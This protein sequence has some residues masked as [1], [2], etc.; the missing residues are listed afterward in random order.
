MLRRWGLYLVLVSLIW[1]GAQPSGVAAQAAPFYAAEAQALL[2]QMSVAER[3]GQLFLIPFYGDTAGADSEIADLIVNHHIGGVVMLTENDNVTD[4]SNAPLQVARLNQQLQELALRP[5][6]EDLTSDPDLSQGL[7]QPRTPIP[8]FIALQ[9]E[10]DG[11]PHSDLWHGLTPIPNQMALGATW[12]PE[13]ARLVGEIVGR[14]LSILGVNLLLGPSLD[15]L[16]NPDPNS[17]SDLGTRTFGGDPYW[18]GLMG[19]AYTQGVQQGSQGSMAVIAK[20][21][22]GYGGSDRPLNEEIATVRKSLAELEQ[23]DLAP[24][25]MVTASDPALTATVRVDG[26]LT[27]HIRYQGLSGNIR[28]TTAPVSFSPTA[29]AELMALPELAEWRAQGG[30]VVSDALGVQA[31]QRFYDDT[32][33]EFPHRQVAKDAFL[34][35]NDLLYL[36]EFALAATRTPESENANIRDTIAWFQERYQ[37]EPAFRQRVDASVLR[38]LQLKLRLYGGELD[39]GFEAPMPEVWSALQEQNASVLV[40][41]PS[42]ALTL[43][44]PRLDEPSAGLPAPPMADENIVIFTQLRLAQACS[45]CPP[46]PYLAPTALQERILALYGPFASGQVAPN[47]IRSFT[48]ADLNDYLDAG[49]APIVWNPPTPTPTPDPLTT[50]DAAAPTPTAAPPA[51]PPP[52]FLVQ[53]ALREADWLLFALLD[54]QTDVEAAS[55]NAL[56]R[57]LSERPDLARNRR[58]VVMAYNIPYSL[59]ATDISKLTAYFG[60]YSKIPAFVDASIQAL[61]NDI[62]LNGNPPVSLNG[63]GYD[64]FRVTQPDPQQQLGLFIYRDGERLMPS[65]NQPV[66][67]EPDETVEL[68]TG[69]IVDHNGNPVPDGAVVRFIQED[70]TENL[71]NVVTERTTQGGVASLE[72]LLPDRLVGRIRVRLSAGEANRSDEIYILGNEALVI[73]PT[74]QPTRTPTATPTLTPSPT[75]TPSPVPSPTLTPTPPAPAPERVVAIPLARVQTLL[76]FLGGVLATVVLALLVMSRRPVA[77]TRQVRQLLWA[78]VAGLLAYNY[79]ALGLPGMSWL[80]QPNAGLGLAVTFV[81]GAAGFFLARRSA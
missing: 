76:G 6:A 41:L 42:Q 49:G 58:V 12:E 50:P 38:L 31:V 75:A 73:T 23:F 45:A 33:Q 39:R 37:V 22:P 35:G 34:A 57:M 8:L 27:T 5:L 3:V 21:F 9:Y 67:L 56:Q 74:P 44:S 43:I 28:A 10:G 17:P 55:L 54:S 64:L 7:Q 1:L 66:R 68:R 13:N 24:F 46:E 79:L 47:R 26:L 80:G 2:E 18:V 29:Q 11:P 63:I 53:E 15:V 51:E 65:P 81:G 32:G 48:F 19:R 40:S 52:A 25:F 59:D 61:F 72:F 70:L 4:L 14:E 77:L 78:L 62:T 30:I 71:L 36:A 69:V 60:V 20:H 16:E